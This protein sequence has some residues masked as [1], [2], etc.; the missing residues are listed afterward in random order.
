[1]A[2]AGNR[3]SFAAV[4]GVYAESWLTGL[5]CFFAGGAF[6]AVYGIAAT[7][8]GDTSYKNIVLDVRM[9][10]ACHYLESTHLT[11]REIAYLLDY[12]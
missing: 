4:G 12:A 6:S 2:C 7:I 9:A 5:L 3:W 1:M 11:I 10:L 8:L